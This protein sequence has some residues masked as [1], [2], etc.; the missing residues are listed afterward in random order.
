MGEVAGLTAAGEDATWDD[1]HGFWS[2]LGDRV[3]KYAAWGD[4]FDRARPFPRGDGGFTVWY[5]RDGRV[6]GVLTHEAD[7]DYERGR[8]LIHRGARLTASP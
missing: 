8:D 6:V 4:G 2:V 7:E 1:V 3:L 5:E